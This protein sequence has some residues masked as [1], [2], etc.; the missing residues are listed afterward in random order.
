MDA[1]D[2]KDGIPHTENGMVLRAKH[3]LAIIN[4]EDPNGNTPLSEAASGGSAT[5]LQLL[6]ER[7]ADVNSQGQFKRTPLYR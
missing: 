1:Q 2:T 4:C 7:G 3:Q 6:L 5:T